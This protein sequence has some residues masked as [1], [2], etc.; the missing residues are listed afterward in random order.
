[1]A[2][3]PQMLM[4]MKINNLEFRKT[5]SD[6]FPVLPWLVSFSVYLWFIF[7]LQE[8]LHPRNVTSWLIFQNTGQGAQ[9]LIFSA[10]LWDKLLR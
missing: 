8:I 6:L 1:M 9:M 4:C 2:E 5:N 3:S 10:Q 7:Y